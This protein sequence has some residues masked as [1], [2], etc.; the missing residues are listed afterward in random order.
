MSHRD[1][2]NN[3]RPVESETIDRV[4]TALRE[5]VRVRPAWRAALL[6]GIG[7]QSNGSSASTV[8]RWSFRPVTAL[9]AAIAC[10][11]VGATLAAFLFGRPQRDQ[12]ASDV[13]TNLTATMPMPG[14][15]GTASVVRFVVVA[16]HASRVSLGIVEWDGALTAA[17]LLNAAD[18]R[19]YQSKHMGRAA[20]PAAE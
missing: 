14:E 20:A 11:M 1:V 4:I 6:A 2:G 5:P 9:A 8:A 10:M 15:H 18:R 3:R 7:D 17:E 13:L 16:P 19:M 12:S